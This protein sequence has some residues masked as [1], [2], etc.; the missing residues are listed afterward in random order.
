MIVLLERERD[1]W[2]MKVG[3]RQRQANEWVKGEKGLDG[4]R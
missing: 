4:W 1:E 2:E 3:V